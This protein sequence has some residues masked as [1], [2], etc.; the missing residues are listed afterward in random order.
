M[1]LLVVFF[2]VTNVLSEMGGRGQEGNFYECSL[3][4]LQKG[5]KDMPTSMKKL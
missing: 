5:I 2:K 3:H 1:L 4:V